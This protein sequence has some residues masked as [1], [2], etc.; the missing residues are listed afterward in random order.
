MNTAPPRVRCHL[1]PLSTRL[2]YKQ[3]TWRR[4]ASPLCRLQP[5]ELI[6]QL[7]SAHHRR[8]WSPVWMDCELIQLAFPLIPWRSVIT[9]LRNPLG[10]S[11]ALSLE[12]LAVFPPLQHALYLFPLSVTEVTVSRYKCSKSRRMEVSALWWMVLAFLIKT[13]PTAHRRWVS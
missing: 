11:L 7:S 12:T 8:H 2:G 3:A 13:P 4:D 1:A 10:P 6:L 9:V 5:K